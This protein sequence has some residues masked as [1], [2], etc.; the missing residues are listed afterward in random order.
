MIL[1]FV[2]DARL[3]ASFR[4]YGPDDDLPTHFSHLSKLEHMKAAAAKASADGRKRL[5]ILFR[6]RDIFQHSAWSRLFRL[7]PPSYVLQ[8][9]AHALGVQPHPDVQRWAYRSPEFFVAEI[10]RIA[11]WYSSPRSHDKAF[12]RKPDEAGSSSSS[13]TWTLTPLLSSEQSREVLNMVKD[14]HRH[15]QCASVVF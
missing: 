7:T 2:Q 1:C 3:E 8:Q 5:H 15:V 12:V 11:S 10:H 4:L 14:F 6:A 9:W 13:A